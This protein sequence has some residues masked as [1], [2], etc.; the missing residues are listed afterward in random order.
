MRSKQLQVLFILVLFWLAACKSGNNKFTVIGELGDMP[1]QNVVLEEIGVNDV[2]TVVDSAKS[3]DKGHFELSGTA[4]EPGLYRLH[5]SNNRFILLSL[6]KGNVKLSGNWNDLEHYQ[7]N[8]SPASES[9]HRFIIAIDEHLRDFNTMR[10]VLDTLQVRGNDSIMQVAKKEFSDMR[11]SF[12]RFVEQY[13]DT[14]SYLPNAIFAARILNVRTEGDF[15]T[16]FSQ[17]LERRFPNMKTT[18]DFIAYYNTVLSKQGMPA[19]P[20]GNTGVGEMASDITLQ[21]PDGKEIKLSSLRGKYVL[22]DFWAS[23]CG[24]CRGENPNV[25]AAYNK[26]KDKNF[27]VYSV[28]LDEKKD[29]WLKAIHDDNLSWPN[30]VSELKGWE[31][32]VVKQYGI[33]A[34]PSNFLLDTSGRIIAHDL[35]GEALEAQLAQIIK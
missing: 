3:N 8:G 14:S 31:S 1:A 22:L 23:W 9:L 34:I 24:P 12:T 13:A 18:K 17:G 5:F 10:M 6:D 21:N 35:R 11:Q 29:N 32:Q 15:L 4:P 26:Y 7:V 30:H 27:T 33:E 20:S 2:I 16:A 19:A 25:V 28:S